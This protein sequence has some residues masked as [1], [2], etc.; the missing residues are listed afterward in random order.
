MDYFRKHGPLLSSVIAV[1][2]AL[3]ISWSLRTWERGAAPEIILV[4]YAWAIWNRE[5]ERSAR[6]I[7]LLSLMWLMAGVS[8]L[9][10]V[11][12][13]LQANVGMSGRWFVVL[14]LV[15]LACWYVWKLS[16]EYAGEL[17]GNGEPPRRDAE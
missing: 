17:A 14:F 3:A 1:T 10:P 12:Y 16:R 6:K 5:G 7:V 9:E 15:P 11:D 8:Q 4:C 2:L 13:F